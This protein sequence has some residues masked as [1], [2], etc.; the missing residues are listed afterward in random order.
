[1][2]VKNANAAAADRSKLYDMVTAVPE[3]TLEDDELDEMVPTTAVVIADGVRPLPADQFWPN[4][5]DWCRV[6]PDETATVN[7]A[8][9]QE[10]FPVDLLQKAFRIKVEEGQASVE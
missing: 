6:E 7:K 5:T 1:M 8:R 3:Q 4:G 10:R 9:R 2:S